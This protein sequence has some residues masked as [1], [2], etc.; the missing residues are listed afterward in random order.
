M[1]ICDNYLRQ[2]RSGYSRNRFGHMRVQAF[3]IHHNPDRRIRTTTVV[4]F[5]DVCR[6]KK[7]LARARNFSEWRS[8]GS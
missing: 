7:R 3:Y 2:C 8:A 5:K 1:D 6:I 4:Y